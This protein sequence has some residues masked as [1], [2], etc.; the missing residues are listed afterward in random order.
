MSHKMGNESKIAKNEQQDTP[1]GLVLGDL[2]VVSHWSD[3]DWPRDAVELGRLTEIREGYY[4]VNGS[5]RGFKH[6]K[7]VHRQ[8]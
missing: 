8:S 4:Y 5:R 7:L 2:V 6:C 3:F 1:E